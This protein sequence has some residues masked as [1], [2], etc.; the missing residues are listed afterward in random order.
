M[1]IIVD[2]NV[3]A[4][5]LLS[6]S[7]VRDWLTRTTGSPRLVVGK[8]LL[9]ELAG[10]AGVRHYLLDLDRNGLLRRVPEAPFRHD[11]CQSNDHHIIAIAISSRARTLCTNDKALMSDFKNPAFIRKPRGRVHSQPSHRTLLRHTK[12]CGIAA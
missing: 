4:L 12:S 2:N 11:L 1:C 7:P 5:L 8:Q 6:K 10:N 9:R 3:A